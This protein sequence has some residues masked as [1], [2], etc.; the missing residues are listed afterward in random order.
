M[1]NIIQQYNA[2]ASSG[3][4]DF[5][6]DENGM[7][8]FTQKNVIVVDA[9]ANPPVV[10]ISDVVTEFGRFT[11]NELLADISTKEQQATVMRF[12]LFNSAPSNI[13]TRFAFISRFTTDEMLA[14]LIAKE[15]PPEQSAGI[16]LLFTQL[17]YST[18]V[19]LTL[20]ST[21]QGVQMLALMG[22]IAESRIAEILAIS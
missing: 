19:D 12:F 11:A 14:I 17:D 4:T 8:I 20:T 16:K 6:V 10:E 15:A 22:L 5:T 3:L 13:I 9:N 1:Y 7:F 2:G 18:E 21:I